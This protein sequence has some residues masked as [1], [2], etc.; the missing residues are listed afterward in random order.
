MKEPTI[1]RCNQPEGDRACHE[2]S[3]C[4]RLLTR[5]FPDG[6]FCGRDI[7]VQLLGNGRDTISEAESY[8]LSLTLHLVDL[9]RPS[10][11]L[12]T[13]LL[14]QMVHIADVLR[15]VDDVY[16]GG[17]HGHQFR[18]SAE[19]VG[20]V[21]EQRDSRRGKVE[22]TPSH[23]LKQLFGDI[24]LDRTVLTPYKGTAGGRSIPP[25]SCSWKPRGFKWSSSLRVN[26]LYSPDPYPQPPWPIV[27]RKT[28]KVQHLWRNQEVVPRLRLPGKWLQDLGFHVDTRF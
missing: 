2:L 14:H 17:F 10:Q 19:E 25:W 26:P 22:T 18:I 28:A 4:I 20:L 3:R 21:V 8:E 7:P 16:P 6:T 23:S 5:V 15:G 1:R 9:L 12:L 11:E 13:I 27:E 24:H